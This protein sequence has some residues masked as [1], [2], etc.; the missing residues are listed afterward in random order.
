MVATHCRPS[1][2]LAA[3]QIDVPSI[4]Q[5]LVRMDD[6]TGGAGNRRGRVL[7]LSG[8][9]GSTNA[10]P[11]W[12]PPILSNNNLRTGLNGD[13]WQ[14]VQVPNI[15]QSDSL[16]GAVDG[17]SAEYSGL[18]TAHP[19]LLADIKND[20]GTG[21]RLLETS[22]LYFD[23]IMD[24]CNTNYGGSMPTLVVGMSWGAWWACQLALERASGMYPIVGAYS[25][26][27][28]N[29]FSK[30]NPGVAGFP[31]LPGWSAQGSSFFSGCSLSVSA[32]NSV[33]LPVRVTWGY[34]DG[35]ITGGNSSLAP[36]T[37]CMSMMANA[38]SALGGTSHIGNT[39]ITSGTGDLNSG[40]FAGGT[41]VL[42]VGSTAGFM[43]TGG[44]GALTGLSNVFGS[45]IV[46]AFEYAGVGTGTLTGVSTALS[47][48]GVTTNLIPGKP[49]LSTVGVGTW[50]GPG[51]GM[52]TGLGFPENH[53][54]DISATHDLDSADCLSWFS[55]TID[56]YFP[57]EF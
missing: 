57:K 18:T 40:A 21:A 8:L 36:P 5:S 1:G 45:N 32:L 15:P 6:A 23:H 29:D 56:A 26:C 20:S 27:N 35:F 37:D 39:T 52:V 55:S 48:P 28:V 46:V 10:N 43:T 13:G 31:I 42:N 19:A 25:H 4:N 33:T 34:V 12:E 24:F 22:L 2:S 49:C 53:A 9:G 38:C 14:T 50:S 30:C 41:G 51:S 54:W 16:V 3:Y 7:L 11:F 17:I 44:A 47:L